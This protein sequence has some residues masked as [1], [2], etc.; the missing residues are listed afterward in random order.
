MEKKI[1]IGF[2]VLIIFFICFALLFVYLQTYYDLTIQKKQYD[3]LLSQVNP[4]KKKIIIVGASSVAMLNVTHIDKKLKMSGWEEYEAY[5]LTRDGDRPTQR[6][7]DIEEL[8]YLK[9]EIVFYGLGTREFG[10]NLFSPGSTMCTPINQNSLV[11]L[12]NKML[13]KSQADNFSDRIQ[14][15]LEE[16]YFES[17]AEIKNQITKI[18]WKNNLNYLD[19]PKLV[20]VYF[21]DKIFSQNNTD[22][23]PTHNNNETDAIDLKAQSGVSEI[24]SNQ[25]LE[26]QT[27]GLVLAYCRQVQ[28]EEFTSLSEIIKQI[29]AENIKI[30]LFTAPYSG[31][32]LEKFSEVGIRHYFLNLQNLAEDHK[33]KAYTF[34]D[35]YADKEIFY[36]LTHVSKS[37]EGNIFSDDFSEF[38]IAVIEDFKKTHKNTPV[39][40]AKFEYENISGENLQNVDFHGKSL[41]EFNFKNSHLVNSNFSNLD[42]SNLD[43]RF[44]NLEGS[45]LSFTSMRGTSLEGANLG[46]SNLTGSD[47]SFT[48]FSGSDLSFA[49]LKNVTMSNSDF[50]YSIINQGFFGNMIF[51]NISFAGASLFDTDFSNTTFDSVD[52]SKANLSLSNFSN[53]SFN[54]VVFSGA[55][56]INSDF[57][58]T[59]L[60][61]L[62]FKSAEL[63]RAIFSNSNLSSS[64]FDFAQMPSVNLTGLNLQK[65]SLVAVNLSESR[66]ENSD[67][68][69]TDSKHVILSNAILIDANLSNSD[70]TAANFVNADLSGVNLTNTNLKFANFTG[71]NLTDADLRC[72]G[73]L[74]CK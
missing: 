6:I 53:S 56:L 70:F 50:S 68:S 37:P 15:L 74:I 51:Q 27:H 4:E 17:F 3:K 11:D 36:D 20:T 65:S 71:A 26:K 72:F 5:K 62:T 42:L 31:P 52:F 54:D 35:R 73:H 66:L 9:P 46:F 59:N 1:Q 61:G 47:L 30:V 32:F 10:Y 29:E 8:I 34:L 18:I 19:D 13:N 28:D 2:V 55:I 57:S 64:F 69:Y 40:L 67:L 33:I 60:S 16:G 38:A 14:N 39:D 44:A 63:N 45:D 49:D 48:S 41:S 7:L 22:G 23:V 24:T 21:L 43:M 25:Q 12:E 58:N